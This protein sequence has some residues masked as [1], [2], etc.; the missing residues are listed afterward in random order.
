[1]KGMGEI[2]LVLGVTSTHD[3]NKPMSI[4]TK[5]E[6]I[7][8]TLAMFQNMDSKRWTPDRAEIQQSARG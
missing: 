2:N 8:D 7:Q 5:R 6:N 3:Y 4:I 1:M